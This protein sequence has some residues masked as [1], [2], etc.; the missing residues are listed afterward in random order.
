M[1]ARRDM[2]SPIR[3]EDFRLL[4]GRAHFTDDVHLDRMVHGVFIRSPVAHAEIVSI[5]TGVA[6]D[7]GALLILTAKDLPFID[8]KYVARDWHPSIRNGEAPFMATDRVRYVGEPVAFLVAV[9]RY[10]AEDLASLVSVEYRSLAAFPSAGAALQAGAE[11]LHPE[12]TENIA[13]RFTLIDGDADA[14]YSAA[15]RHL[16]RRFRFARQIPLPIETRG[17]VADFDTIA[18]MLN[19]WTSTQCHYR[20]R[21]NLA[22]ILDLGESSIR[23]IAEDVG[24]GFG[25]KSRPYGE[26]IIVPYA[27]KVLER[28]VKWI[29]DRFEHMQATTHSR[30]VDTE[31]RVAYDDDGRID[32]LVERIIVDIGAYVFSSGIVTAEIVAANARGPYRIPNV[33]VEVLCVGTNKT[34]L[35]TYRGAGQPEA[36]FPLESVLDIVAKDLDISAAEMR[37]RNIVRPSDMPYE[38]FPHCNAPAAFDSGDYPEMLAT[39]VTGSGYTEEVIESDR[40][41]RTAWGLACGVEGSGLINYESARVAIDGSGHVTVRSGLTSQGQ[42]QATTCAQVCA[43]ALGVGIDDVTVR[44]GDTDLLSFGRGAFASRGAILGANAVA[45]AA[46]TLRARLI[47][48]AATILQAEP[49][50]L[51]IRDGR[52]GSAQGESDLTIAEIARSVQPGGPFYSGE[53]ALQEEFVF[54]S[55]GVL[56]LGLSVHVAQVVLDPRSGFYR[57]S[58]YYILHDAGRLLNPVIADGQIV[59][60][61]VDGI[62][63]ALFSEIM[64]NDEAQPLNGTLAD[65]LVI[66]APEAPRVRVEHFD[67]RPTTNPLGVRGIGESGIIGVGAAIGNALARAISSNEIGHEIFLSKLPIVPEMVLRAQAAQG[68]HVDESDY[69]TWYSDWSSWPPNGSV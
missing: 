35:A 2:N 40:G 53:T 57:V 44:L 27:S 31:I 15:P 9:D 66:T 59:G 56:T 36:T 54:D 19:L 68:Q 49:D 65:Y 20:V 33:S 13:A 43:E 22:S 3:K 38:R 60:G 55:G 34:P 24:G 32:A 5:D 21:D 39:A 41:E 14:A 45:G 61:V 30:G 1:N 26:E 46:Q 28:P 23:V 64:F 6:M 16:M 7:A 51:F 58:D 62:G 11:R 50:G 42:G 8:R 4:S 29:E 67:T 48:L 63:G 47:A 17:C 12:W 25:S 10:Q 69:P 37:D 52:I 18:R